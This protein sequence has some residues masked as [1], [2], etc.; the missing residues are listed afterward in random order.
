VRE[1]GGSRTGE[2]GVIYLRFGD[3]PQGGRSAVLWGTVGREDGT[4]VFEAQAT[5]WGGY[6]IRLGHLF[7]VN[8]LARVLKERR[9]LYRIEGTVIGRGLSGEPL[10]AD[11]RV[12]EAVGPEAEIT[13][14]GAGICSVY[15][16][17]LIARWSEQRRRSA[18]VGEL[19]GTGGG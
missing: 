11:A 7:Q 2:G 3:L 5:T 19:L 12:V 9:P 13:V 15:L 4:S 18:G 17:A 6:E 8:D 16:R 10:L 1:A 14:E